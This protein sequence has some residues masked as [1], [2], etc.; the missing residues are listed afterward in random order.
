[1]TAI[2][3]LQGRTLA[4]AADLSVDEQR[5]LYRKTRELKEA[6]HAGGDLS[7]FRINDPDLSVYL[8]F[9]EDST[10][11]KESFR[12]AAKFHNI[13][14]NVFDA[15]SSSFKKSESLV[16]TVKMLFGYGRRSI[17]V[18]R[19]KM[20]GVCLA[21]EEQ[22]GE[23]AERL[24]R[25]RPV[26]INA[27]DGRHEHPTQEFLDEFTFL[28]QRNWDDTH[29]HV[30]L[31][32]DLY[33]GRT[34]HSKADGLKAFRSVK[35]DLVAPEE[36]SLPA[37][38]KT[39][40]E[41]NGFE[42]REW[43]N[44][45][46]YLG[47]GDVS[48]CWYFTRLQLE[49]MGD[50]VRER[51]TELR[52]AVTFRQKWLDALPQE[53]R[54]YHPLP[55]HREKP[56]IPS[57]LDATPLNGWDGQSINGYFTRI[58]ELAMV[59]GRLG[60]D[61][62]GSGPISE[63]RE[64]SFIT[65]VPITRKSR[66]EDRFKVGIKPVDDGTVIDHIAKGRTPEEIWDRI[67]KIR[68]ILKL[69]VRGSHGVFHTADPKDFKGIMSLPDILEISHTEL[70]KLAAVS[71]GCTVNLIQNRSVK[72]KYR[73]AMPPKIYNFAEIS[74]KNPECVTWPGAYQHVP[75]HFYRTVGETFT[76]RY[77]GRRHE[78]GDIWDL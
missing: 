32:G 23:Y 19:T 15:S 30:A 51:E 24:G 75:P 49:R 35:V 61:F 70:K 31:I 48:N 47:S 67:Y 64:K 53:T 77:C 57:F 12:N 43:P 16:D 54:F 7:P 22:L 39:R 28:E 42:V 6:W 46:E 18:M 36:L 34:V 41:E 66:V 14:T 10:R 65:E 5:Y 37:S 63:P 13:T 3:P 76:C 74:C 56:V 20:E 62:E 8:M 58:I 72:A 60:S 2:N 21:L 52:R 26:F 40:M 27:G 4:A 33:H 59:A 29:I 25:E 45:A 9:L 17:F 78:Y 11:T 69:N 55:R 44:I 38:Y 71:P 73:L 68:R 50:E 1:M